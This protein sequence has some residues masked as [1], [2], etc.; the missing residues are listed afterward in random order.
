MPLFN[1]GGA[2]ANVIKLMTKPERL[3]TKKSMGSFYFSKIKSAYSFYGMPKKP[4]RWQKNQY[5]DA[6]IYDIL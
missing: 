1:E 5:A 6:R 2:D 4:H 3:H